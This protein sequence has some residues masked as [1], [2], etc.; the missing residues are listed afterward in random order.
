MKKYSRSFP[1]KLVVLGT[2]VSLGSLGAL[3]ACGSR[4]APQS[5][6]QPQGS[7][8]PAAA[9]AAP[10]EDAK[11]DH[12]GETHAKRSGAVLLGTQAPA[13]T[14]PLLD[15]T[16]V[17][18]ADLRGK[19]VYLKFWATWCVPCRE[20]MPHFEATYQKHKNELA[21]YA[22]DLGL[23]DS[24]EAVRAFQ[25]EHK[26]TMP[27]AFDGDGAL[28]QLLHVSV[29]PQHILIDRAGVI[30][31]VGHEDNAE[32]GS[33]LE[34][35][36]RD[37]AT[38]A[39]AGTTTT[40]APSAARTAA[41]ADGPLTLAL[42]DGSS[43]S[44][45]A[46]AGKPVALTFMSAWCDWYL[47]ETRPT[48]SK[49]CIAHV[50]KVDEL[51]RAHPDHVWISVASPVWTSPQDLDEYQKR[52]GLGGAIGIDEGS[53]WF[54]RHRVREVPATLFFDGKGSE[55]RRVEGSGEELAKGL[56]S[57]K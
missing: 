55:V 44:F 11:E 24:E 40:P 15:G 46:N 50:K 5:T 57:A 27:I 26:I 9:A 4:S 23:N 32:L 53:V 39:A 54:Q 8:A 45:A 20:Q 6:E 17:K 22:I 10:E 19:P 16:K 13:A 42:R 28:A 36:L 25:A 43:F 48:M 18:L 47:A 33:A 2:F 31:H 3:G 12:S 56:T 21:V 52:L 49:A 51:R 35:I 1:A 41:A 14:L 29:T 7:A 30:R 38:P 34:K 37:E